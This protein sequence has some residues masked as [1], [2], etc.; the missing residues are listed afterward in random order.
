M[1][2]DVVMRA[3]A[4]DDGAFAQFVEH[5]DEALR[6]LVYLLLGEPD[7]LDRILQDA[8]VKAYR[9]LPQFRRGSSPGTWLFRIVYHCCID[10]LRR[11]LRR[12][13]RRGVA[14]S[15]SS[16]DAPSTFE[17]AL[18]RLPADQCAV[19]VLIDGEGFEHAAVGD[20]LDLSPASVSNR[21]IKARAALRAAMAGD[22]DVYG[23]VTGTAIDDPGLDA[24]RWA[25]AEPPTTAPADKPEDGISPD[26][27]ADAAQPGDDGDDGA[28]A[29]VRHRT[30]SG[31]PTMAEPT[32]ADIRPPCP[33]RM[34]RAVR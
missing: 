3:R 32:M 6:R 29:L 31:A 8:Y 5:Y 2:D 24:S 10:E 19:V 15:R 25:A 26:S 14:P 33:T 27:A 4:G 20:V 30:P 28:R 1:A 16:Q 22:E 9:A 7:Q 12:P 18:R 23:V 13:A 17:Q 11:R 21:L 34:V